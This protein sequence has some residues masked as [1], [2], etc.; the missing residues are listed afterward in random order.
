VDRVL[1]GEFKAAL[2]ALGLLVIALTLI[3]WLMTDLPLLPFLVG[4]AIGCLLGLGLLVVA[5]PRR[6]L[7]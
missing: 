6:R 7:P 3:Y 1:W 4:E 5:A 2:K